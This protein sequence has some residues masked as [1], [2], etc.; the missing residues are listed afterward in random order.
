VAF[1]PTVLGD[2][3]L[4]LSPA[5]GTNDPAVTAQG[6]NALTGKV[7]WSVS[8]PLIL[9]DAPAVCAGGKDF[10]LAAAL[11]NTTT[12]LVVVNAISGS[13]LG[14]VPGPERNMAVAQPG[15]T[16]EGDLW[17]TSSPTPTLMETSATGRA[18]WTDTVSSLFGGNQYNPDYGWDFL[19]RGSLDVGSIANSPTGHTLSLSDSKTIGISAPDGTLSWTVPGYYLCGGGLQFLT[20]DVVCQYS[21]SARQTKTSVDMS[22]VSLTLAGLNLRSGMTTWSE[23][24]LGAQ[25][26]SLG[27]NVAFVDGTHLVV[28]V[29]SRARVVLDVQTGETSPVTGNKVFWCEQDPTY[30][31]KTAQGASV[32]GERVSAPVFRS[33][34]AQGKPVNGLPLTAPSTVGVRAGGRFVWP[35]PHGLQAIQQLG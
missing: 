11:S 18:A 5:G 2:I 6:I 8:Q 31:V 23:H 1:G 21:G 32:K 16:A 10:C 26:L 14:A 12:G 20:A 15:S 7:L 35:T 28:Q 13:V 27:T 17:Q 3:V 34:S 9:T 25:A 19:V 24:V 22:G 33:C 30:K 4:A 29:P